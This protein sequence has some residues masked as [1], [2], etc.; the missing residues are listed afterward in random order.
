MKL[1]AK[2]DYGKIAEI[3]KDIDVLSFLRPVISVTPIA[4][5]WGSPMAFSVVSNT[6]ISHYEWDFGDGDTRSIQSDNIVHTYTRA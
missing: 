4:T 5:S 3:T 6:A 1:I 2:D